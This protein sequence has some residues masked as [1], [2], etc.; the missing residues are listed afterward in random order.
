MYLY[1]EK[2]I[3]ASEWVKDQEGNPTKV[4]NPDYA[5]AI[6]GAG[7]DKLPDSAYGD[8][9]IRK[10]IGYW[11][12][13]NAV[14]G[15]FVNELANGIDECQ[16]IDVERS[17]LERLL[18]DCRN[19]LLSKDMAVPK[20]EDT[21]VI[22]VESEDVGKTIA[23]RFKREQAKSNR[24]LLLGDPLEPV[25]GFFFGST[26][27]DEYYYESIQETADLIESILDTAGEDTRFIYRASW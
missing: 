9:V 11:R 25:A 1:A 21:Q 7:M 23:E 13:A 8:V 22:N 19:A 2:S 18:N 24:V 15:W 4:G 14:H 5:K 10:Q 12:K 20:V 17:D 3:S 26:E 27:K 6:K 16:E